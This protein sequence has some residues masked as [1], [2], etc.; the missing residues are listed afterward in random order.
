M[1]EM[2]AIISGETGEIFCVST[3]HHDANCMA[4]CLHHLFVE[5]HGE[6]AR[7]VKATEMSED[8]IQAY[9]DPD[10]AKRIKILKR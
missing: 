7:E 6:N 4:L 1:T 2:W 8:E 10:P 5:M 9:L 3:F